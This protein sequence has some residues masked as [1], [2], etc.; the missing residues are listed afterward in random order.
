M[1]QV[2]HP[3]DAYVVNYFGKSERERD[4]DREREIGLNLDVGCVCFIQC[5]GFDTVA[6]SVVCK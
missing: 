1:R 4:V 3:F 6:I 2:Y 5:T